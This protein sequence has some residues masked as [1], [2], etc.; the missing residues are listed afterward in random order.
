MFCLLNACCLT[1]Q[2]CLNFCEWA[3]W[4]F[5]SVKT[6]LMFCYSTL[7]LLRDTIKGL[8]EEPLEMARLSLPS[9]NQGPN[10]TSVSSIRNRSMPKF[11]EFGISGL[12]APHLQL[13]KSI[14]F[15]CGAY[16]KLNQALVV[17]YSC[18]LLISEM[19]M[20]QAVVTVSIKAS[21]SIISLPGSC[22]IFWP[23]PLLEQVEMGCDWQLTVC[24]VRRIISVHF[25]NGP[26]K[27]QC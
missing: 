18:K 16:E 19:L 22:P 5:F 7:S 14:Y 27:T 8:I 3:T 21:C 24:C 2:S 13:P 9:T 25:K 1:S 15:L 26:E 11:T 17:I 10:F 23:C 4:F 20:L 6:K 12:T